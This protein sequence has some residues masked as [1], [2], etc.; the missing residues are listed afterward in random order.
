MATPATAQGVG[1]LGVNVGVN[2][3]PAIFSDAK[4][5]VGTAS[6]GTRAYVF[7]GTFPSAGQ[8]RIQATDFSFPTTI[9][10]LQF[11]TIQDGAPLG[12]A[13]S[14]GSATVQA[15]AGQFFIVAIT[16]ML[17]PSA[18]GLFGI[19]VSAQPGDTEVLAVAQGVGDL[20]HTRSLTVSAPGKLDVTLSDLDFPAGFQNLALVVTRGNTLVGQIFGSGTFSFSATPGEYSLNFV[21]TN[22]LNDKFGLYGIKIEDSPPEPT[23]SFFANGSSVPAQ[24]STTVTWSTSDAASC[25]ASGDE[26]WSGTKATSGTNVSV[27]PFASNKTLT[28]TCT[29]PGGSKSS[30]VK[31]TLATTQAEKSGGGGIV[32]WQLFAILVLASLR[33]RKC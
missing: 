13:T 26:S 21:A 10:A 29:G 15:K 1:T 7:V 14:G 2:G 3:A 12:A 33:L 20:F 23:V 4:A 30:E 6:I 16:N 25:S 32:V 22:N 5:F 8:H 28:L 18:T 19:S 11:L 24:G 17:S 31:I 27:G 9:P